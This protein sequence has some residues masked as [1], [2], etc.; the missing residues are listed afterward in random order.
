MVEKPYGSGTLTKAAFFQ[1]IRSSL[2]QKSRWWKPI[3]DCKNLSKRKNQGPNKRLKWEFQCNSCK[4][5]FPD[6]EICVD[7]I[8]EAGSLNEFEDLPM[9]TKRLFCE[10]DGLQVLC[11]NK[12][13]LSKTAEYNQNLKQLKKSKEIDENT[14]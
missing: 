2:R 12:C 6:K 7:H 8:E 4:G 5:W 13:H 14:E 10:V 1:M 9:F 3:S 11:K